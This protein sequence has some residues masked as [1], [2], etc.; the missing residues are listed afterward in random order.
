MNNIFV[1]CDFQIKSIERYESRWAVEGDGQRQ[2]IKSAG[3]KVSQI[4]KC[5]KLM[6]N[7]LTYVNK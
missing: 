6:G 7:V 3:K 4:I 2:W 1:F 5:Q